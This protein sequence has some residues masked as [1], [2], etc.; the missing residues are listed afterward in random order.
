MRILAAMEAARE[1]RSTADD[2]VLVVAAWMTIR[3]PLRIKA[4]RMSIDVVTTDRPLLPT[5]SL[6][7]PAWLSQ[8]PVTTRDAACHCHE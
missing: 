3:A 6:V 2:G 7:A 1:K 5:L 4:Q 8:Q